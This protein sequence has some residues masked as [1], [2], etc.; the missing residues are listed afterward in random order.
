MTKKS[1]KP[2]K[3]VLK[4]AVESKKN[5][6][7][8]GEGKKTLKP[9]VES[10]NK[11]VILLGLLAFSYTLYVAWGLLSHSTWDDDCATRYF[12]TLNAFHDP[13]EFISLWNRPLFITV[14]CVPVLILGKLAIPVVM[15]F[16]SVLGAYFLY[17]SA[18]TYQYQYAL[19]IIPFLLFQPYFLGTGRDAMTEPMAA[20]IIAWGLYAALKN[21]WLTFAVLGAILP[22][23]RTE[24]ALLLPIWAF[25]LFRAKEYKFIPV[26]GLGVLIW[27]LAGW[28]IDGD[29]LYLFHQT[30]DKA[31]EENRYGSQKFM[32]YFNRYLYVVGPVVFYFFLLGLFHKIRKLDIKPLVLIQFITGFM[33]YTL[34]AW[35]ISIGQ[36]AGF[37]RN[38][39][40]LSPLAALIALGGFEYFLDSVKKGKNKALLLLLCMGVSLLAIVL[41][42]YEIT[43]HHIISKTKKIDYL[44]GVVL[45]GLGILLGLII[46]LQNWMQPK[47]LR[48]LAIFIGLAT[49]GY[50]L[51]TEPPGANMNSERKMM[52]RVAETFQKCGLENAPRILCSHLWFHWV[53]DYEPLSKGSKYLPMSKDSLNAAPYESVIIWENHYSNRLGHDISFYDLSD[54]GKY[55]LLATFYPDDGT[56]VA[57]MYIK[58]HPDKTALQYQDEMISKNPE[59][60]ELFVQRSNIYLAMKDKEKALQDLNIAARLEPAN[61][62]V[63]LSRASYFLSIGNYPEA[64]KVSDEIIKNQADYVN[65]YAIK[66]NAYFSLNDYPKAIENFKQILIK[67]KDN[68]EANYNLGISYIKLNKIDEAC[69]YLLEAKRLQMPNVDVAI[70]QYCNSSTSQPQGTITN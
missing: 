7:L 36:S 68:K 19:L 23:A 41:F 53:G 45:A 55:T 61:N 21:R 51:Y 30:I 40:P 33:I 13:H 16:I 2:I 14:F 24:L 64:I 47:H 38:L 60:P 17:Q 8:Q 69:K 25:V 9:L 3:K 46:L 59:S 44:N 10:K 32:T 28:V 56:K 12:R 48:G 27:N 66:G 52:T 5:T 43:M 42:P 22:L 35:K 57:Y 1:T 11:R 49:M 6:K 67:N 4:P 54:P 34:L 15:S 26:L 70:T 20:T 37:L 39:I 18:R 63:K 58:K 31:D 50:A 29:A 62:V 65:A